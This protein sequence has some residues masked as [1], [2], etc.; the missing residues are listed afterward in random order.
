MSSNHFLS[1]VDYYKI[2][3]VPPKA[4]IDIETIKKAYHTHMFSVHPD[5]GGDE[6]KTKL[7]NEAYH[8]LGNPT[9]RREYN[10]FR[11]SLVQ[12]QETKQ[13]SR[14]ENIFESRTPTQ[15]PLGVTVITMLS[16]VAGTMAI[17][18]TITDLAYIFQEK[19]LPFW[20][21]G[22]LFIL[23]LI[24]FMI[25]IV[26]YALSNGLWNGHYWAW[27]GSIIYSVFEIF[28]RFIHI[29]FESWNS[30]IW[31]IVFIYITYYLTRPNVKNFFKVR[32]YY[33][34]ECFYN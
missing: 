1:E 29:L 7:L 12:S 31:I 17:Y 20:K 34:R 8:V 18:W 13:R 5:L 21:G 33:K 25:S 15:R 14:E 30:L 28:H 2:L 4:E 16:L 32:T 9:L 19:Y 10:W 24:G 27:K 3:G 6:E 26:T 11:Q 23:S 22:L